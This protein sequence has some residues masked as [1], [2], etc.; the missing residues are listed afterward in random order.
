M[1][2][3]RLLACYAEIAEAPDAV[4]TLRRF[5]LDL[6]VRG[7]LVPQDPSDES[8]ADLL[9]RIGAEKQRLLQLGAAKAEKALLRADRAA[10]FE[11]P[12]SWRWTRLG[13]I[14]SYIQRGKS[15]KYAEG[16]GYPVISQKCVQWTGLDLTAAKQITPE[17]LDDY[18]PIRFLR[19]GDLLWNSTGT[20][21]I[22]RVVRVTRPAERLV[23]DSHVTIVRCLEAV[24]EY[25][26]TWL[27]SDHVYALIEERAAGSTNQVELTAQMAINQ[28]IP[29]PPLAEQH[30]IV[31]KVDELMA[32]CEELEAAR[33]AREAA[34]DR[35]AAASFARLSA[36]APE[37]FQA[38][39]RFALDALPA[40]SAR[41][42]QIKTLRQM[43]LNL[44]VR[45]KLVEQIAADG[46]G[47]DLAHAILVSRG[48]DASRGAPISPMF[49]GPSSWAWLTAAQ[50]S[51]PDAVITYGIL[52]PEWVTSG[53]PTVRVTEM[54]TGRID[55]SN[56][57]QCK[58][59]RARLFERTSLRAG[60]LL[61]SKDGT[62]GK[63][64]FVPP[65]LEGGNITQHVLRFSI[66]RQMDRRFVR[67]AI[68]SPLYQSWMAGETKGVALQGVNVGDFRRM[69]MPVPPLA[70]QHR[71]VAKV[72][73]LMAL[74]DELELSLT[75]VD[76]T[77]SRLLEALLAEA[78]AP[79]TADLQA[80]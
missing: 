68:D 67:L 2:P 59:E 39:A 73:E 7:K 29:V 10:E 31:A 24:P 49:D 32:L 51:A 25:V 3:E 74:C 5:I 4:A 37:T 9:A 38:D 48:E 21:T 43:I 58:P 56:L 14:T 19:D 42:D 36:P 63:T 1:N 77:R 8:A 64:A 65:E 33:M 20:G 40:L 54:K 57:P 23:C 70:E 61:I 47:S 16:D 34:R 76:I 45:G 22:G 71:I 18:E 26:R 50:L 15:P 41:A 78:L 28:A 44:A 46:E 69:P 75:T 80:A 55:T 35:L 6:A 30:R 62:I 72:D 12:S 11:I 13:F 27:R 17:S 66:C 60:D 79:A 52:K 53:V